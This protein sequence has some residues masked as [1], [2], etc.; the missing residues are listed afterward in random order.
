MAGMIPPLPAG[1]GEVTSM[2]GRP[3]RAVI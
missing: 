2:F 1:I 3:E